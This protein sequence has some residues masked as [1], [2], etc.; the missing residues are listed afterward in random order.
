[1]LKAKAKCAKAEHTTDLNSDLE[2]KRQ[3]KK[4][5]FF[6]EKSSRD[7]IAQVDNDPISQQNVSLYTIRKSKTYSIFN[8]L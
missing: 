1:M 2:N 4:K 8:L 3:R 6:D 5:R 7:D